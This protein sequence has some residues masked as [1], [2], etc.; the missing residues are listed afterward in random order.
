MSFT[1]RLFGPVVGERDDI[2]VRRA[3]DVAVGAGHARIGLHEVEAAQV[4]QVLE[5]FV[6]EVVVRLDAVEVLEGAIA[7]WADVARRR[8]AGLDDREQHQPRARRRR[9]KREVVEVDR[10]R[11]ERRPERSVVDVR[12]VQVRERIALDVGKRRAPAPHDL[13]RSIG[14]DR[15]GERRRDRGNLLA[16][17]PRPARA[18]G[19]LDGTAVGERAMAKLEVAVEPG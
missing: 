17:R 3:R 12:V 1:S 14:S 6:V 16:R 10:D 11:F 18:V 13:R 9:T 8:I 5:L 15:G 2:G 7:V 19:Q 4:A